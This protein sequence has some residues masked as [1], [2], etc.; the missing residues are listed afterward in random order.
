MYYGKNANKVL[1]YN[2]KQEISTICTIW[3]SYAILKSYQFYIYD[4]VYFH[5]SIN[6]LVQSAYFSFLTLLFFSLCRY[7]NKALNNLVEKLALYLILIF[8]VTYIYSNINQFVVF[9][10]MWMGMELPSPR[11]PRPN[12]ENVPIYVIKEFK[13]VSYTIPCVVIIASAIGRDY[14]IRYVNKKSQVYELKKRAQSL[15]RQ[16]TSARLE[17]LRMQINPHFLF[18]T[19]HA[20]NTMAGTNPDGVRQATK[21]LGGLLRYA[22]SSSDTQEV[23][24]EEEIRFLR[25]YLEIQKLRLQEDLQF[26]I[27]VDAKVEKA[28]VPTL[29]LQPL[30]ENAI[31]HGIQPLEGKGRIRVTARRRKHRVC[32]QIEDNGPGFEGPAGP[33][34]G[35]GLENV[36]E[37]LT[38]LYGN[39]Y[40]LTFSEAGLG[41]CRV[42]VDMPF[43]TGRDP[44]LEA[45]VEPNGEGDEV[46]VLA[47]QT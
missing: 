2:K 1:P 18:N 17:A 42:E 38:H 7:I 3:F 16:L 34:D 25:G 40:T 44:R 41:G 14:F 28:Q 46:D 21:R 37:R 15:H 10:K 26:E 9:A 30:V 12:L 32:I 24:L 23:A 22:L 39:D 33:N 19:L 6:Y 47:H 31:K 43:H 4:F 29:L 5:S 11:L 45:V 27:D 8:L 36:R 35:V 20:I 13:F